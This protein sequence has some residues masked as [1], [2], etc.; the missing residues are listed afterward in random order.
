V[1][2]ARVLVVHHNKDFRRFM[3]SLLTNEG[4]KVET[5]TTGRTAIAKGARTRFD[6]VVADEDLGMTPASFARQVREARILFLTP[7]GTGFRVPRGTTALPNPPR[8]TSLL[9]KIKSLAGRR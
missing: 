5:A 4:Y 1:V 6:L 7:P 2:G 9:A 3:A 8:F